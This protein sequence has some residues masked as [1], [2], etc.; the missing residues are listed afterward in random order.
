[1]VELVHYILD[2]VGIFKIVGV[3]NKDDQY[4]ASLVVSIVAVII[5]CSML[6]YYFI[7]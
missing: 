6:V 2:K 1:M 7:F 3:E 5:L 4:D